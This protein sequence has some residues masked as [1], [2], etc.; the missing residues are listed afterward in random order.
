MYD[1]KKV[2]IWLLFLAHIWTTYWF[3]QQWFW[4]YNEV[5]SVISATCKQQ[6]IV[7]WPMFVWNDFAHVQ[8]S[9]QWQWT[10]VVWFMVQNQILP[11]FQEQI[12]GKRDISLS[13]DISSSP[14]ASTIPSDATIVLLVQGNVE[15]SNIIFEVGSKWFFEKISAWIKSA[16]QYI[17][18]SPRTINFME[19]PMWNGKY[20]NQEF[21][22]LIIILLVVL[23][24]L[25][26]ISSKN[27]QKIYHIAVI[28]FASLWAFIDIFSTINQQNMYANIVGNKDSIMKN[29]RLA[30]GNDF[31]DFLAY[32]KENTPRWTLWFFV[33]PYPYWF[34]WKYHIY[35]HISIW[36][37]TWSKV[38]FY[39]NP[40]WAAAQQFWFTDPTIVGADNMVWNGETVVFTKILEWKPYAK[41]FFIQ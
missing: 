21:F 10:I 27:K 6:C 24:V 14:Q 12:A 7:V 35:P 1:M 18:Y 4:T 28:L 32:I 15:L 3:E 38:L 22:W 37:Y 29:W 26:L 8:G 40:M 20:I 31:Y 25:Y 2:L 36:T 30:V 11:I 23:S 34:E 19:W 41:V 33:A 39:Y 5:D 16:S 17:A 13:G 9:V